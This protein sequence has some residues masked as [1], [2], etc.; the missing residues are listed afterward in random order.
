MR[1]RAWQP[2][3]VNHLACRQWYPYNLAHTLLLPELSTRLQVGTTKA[4]R[5]QD[6]KA[7]SKAKKLNCSQFVNVSEKALEKSRLET[8]VNT[9]SGVGVGAGRGS[10]D[11]LLE[12][13]QR[14]LSL[15]AL[16]VSIWLDPVHTHQQAYC[17]LSRQTYIW[18]IISCCCWQ[19]KHQLVS[20]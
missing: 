16:K 5:R 4:T 7:A 19:D 11:K 9:G 3:L 18:Y 15:C 14:Q 10:E 2:R 17:I 13:G 12:N 1:G 20:S 6:E 8:G